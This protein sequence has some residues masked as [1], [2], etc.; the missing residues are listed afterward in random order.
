MIRY[1][2][3]SL[4]LLVGHL[5]AIPLPIPT[6]NARAATAPAPSPA[7]ETKKYEDVITKVA[8]STPG[9]FTVH[10]IRDKIFYEIPAGALGRD[11]LWYTEVTKAP[12][13]IG[14]GGAAIGSRSVRWERVGDRILLRLLSFDKRA[15]IEDPEDPPPVWRAVE[16][17]SLPPIVMAFDVE[18]EG[19][20]GSAV[21]DAT[22]LLTSNVEE[23]S[24]EKIFTQ[25]GVSVRG[26]DG[27]AS[28]D[29]SRAYVEEVKAFPG[30]IEARSVITFRVS[31]AGVPDTVTQRPASVP[32]GD[33]RSAS[34]VVH[35]SMTLLP[36]TPMR[37]RLF[38]PRVGF[39]AESY[40]D[41]SKGDKKV[42]TRRHINRFRL[43]KKNPEDPVS[44]PVKPVVFFIGREVPVEWRPYI[45][46][47]VEDWQPPFEAAGFRNA[48]VA[49]DAPSEQED[50]AWDPEDTRYSVIRWGA[51]PIQNAIGPNVHDPRSGEILS[52]DIVIYQ[53]ILKL[54][55]Q[56]YFSMCAA[57]DPRAK[58]LPLPDEIGRAHV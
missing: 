7:R 4:C 51:V 11:M 16:D 19:N 15:E 14:Y 29:A 22:K 40:E 9:L 38:D 6:A 44:E 43:E 13:G 57:L 20:G 8:V 30:N 12:A 21:I 54:A 31:P 35:Y 28:I 55:Q 32:P 47:A 24:A 36:E 41:Y 46:K 50:P 39:F 49:R 58:R 3:L 56:W 37:A 2:L 1:R 17:A 23:F 48:I 27:R 53:D 5:S 52:A 25:S 34:L 10:R 42:V 33:I 45:R 18:A 26:A